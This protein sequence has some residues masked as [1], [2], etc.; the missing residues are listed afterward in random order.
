M[1]MAFFKRHIVSS[2]ACSVCQR[3]EEEESVMHALWTC[4]M[5]GRFGKLCIRL[6]LSIYGSGFC[7]WIDLL[8]FIWDKGSKNNVEKFAMIGWGHLEQKKCY[9]V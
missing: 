5:Q 6:M 9:P 1:L 3:E 7:F 2:K 8:H 4:G